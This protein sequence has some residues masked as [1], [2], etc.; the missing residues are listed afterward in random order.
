[1]KYVKPEIQVVKFEKEDILTLSG[2]SIV[3]INWML[4]TIAIDDG[5]DSE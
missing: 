5:S 4:P 3:G 2:G 1:M